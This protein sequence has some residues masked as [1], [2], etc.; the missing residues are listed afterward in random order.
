MDEQIKAASASATSNAMART[1]RSCL[2]AKE[3]QVVA[4]KVGMAAVAVAPAEM[5]GEKVAETS[6]GNVSESSTSGP[7]SLAGFAEV[8]GL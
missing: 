2:A 5:E 6:N 3:R 1:P 8:P 4:S 7:V